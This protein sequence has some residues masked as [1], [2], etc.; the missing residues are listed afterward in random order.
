MK[1]I[2]SLAMLSACITAM[3]VSSCSK[4]PTVP[5]EYGKDGETREAVFDLDD[6]NTKTSIRE[7]VGNISIDWENT[8]NAFIHIFENGKEGNNAKI[9]VNKNA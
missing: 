6:V 8:N 5:D 2:V 9:T 7:K 4:E 3:T 1:K